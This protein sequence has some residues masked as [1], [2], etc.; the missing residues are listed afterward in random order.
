MK[1]HTNK[2]QHRIRRK[3]Q[4][5]KLTID[6]EI[7]VDVP[8]SEEIAFATATEATL[9]DDV[10]SGDLMTEIKAAAVASGDDAIFASVTVDASSFAIDD[11]VN[12]DDGN[13]DV[14]DGA[15]S[16]ATIGVAAVVSVAASMYLM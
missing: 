16:K 5:G 8:V 3:L 9:A 7:K 6:F 4:T 10:A 13:E 11:V 1:H 15:A 2:T 14:V 12:P